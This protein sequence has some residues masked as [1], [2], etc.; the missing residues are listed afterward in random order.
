MLFA[1]IQSIYGRQQTLRIGKSFPFKDKFEMLKACGSLPCVYPDLFHADPSVSEKFIEAAIAQGTL[2]VGAS[3]DWLP[4]A[5]AWRMNAKGDDEERRVLEIV[6]PPSDAAE[7]AELLSTYHNNFGHAG[8]EYVRYL[9]QNVSY[10]RQALEVYRKS[11]HQKLGGRED[12]RLL[13]NVIAC[14]G[15]AAQVCSHLG[16]LHVTA[17]RMVKHGGEL[18]EVMRAKDYEVAHLPEKLLGDYLLDR[19]DS[20]L[21]MDGGTKA[22]KRDEVY[23]DGV[24]PTEIR[25]ERLTRR[26]Y[27][28]REKFNDWCKTRIQSG[29]QMVRLLLKAGVALKRETMR[30]LRSSHPE[31]GLRPNPRQACFEVNADHPLINAS[32]RRLERELKLNP[33]V[34]VGG[35]NQFEDLPASLRTPAPSPAT[36]PESD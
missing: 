23:Y 8:L 3:S 28:S 24:S 13:V 12:E 19:L 9:S 5:V 10:F 32:V 16:L 27:I 1:G 17:E 11:V 20:V 15:M 18:L 36:P 33:V 30:S 31:V 14:V 2:L 26:L 4:R 34:T 7:D 21:V 35:A 22:S 25:Y 6:L 29:H